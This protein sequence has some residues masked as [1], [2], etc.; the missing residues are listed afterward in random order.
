[1]NQNITSIDNLSKQKVSPTLALFDINLTTALENKH[2]E[3]T[4]GAHV[5][6]KTANN[7]VA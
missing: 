1:M 6:L 3:N 4:R 2:R 5:L 7:Y